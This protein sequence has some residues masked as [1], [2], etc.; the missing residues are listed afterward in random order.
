MNRAGQIQLVVLAH[1][2][3]ALD[4]GA[5]E[6]STLL[7]C[8]SPFFIALLRLRGSACRK[9]RL[10]ASDFP[11]AKER[12]LWCL[13]NR[14]GIHTAAAAAALVGNLRIVPKE[15]ASYFRR[16]V[17]NGKSVGGRNTEKDEVNMGVRLRFMV[18]AFPA[19]C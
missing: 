17:A 15:H 2:Q 13:P 10:N 19:Y 6:F 1:D 18:A 7:V 9:I 8:I 16:C 5:S 4:I 3:F 11:T 14:T 12:N